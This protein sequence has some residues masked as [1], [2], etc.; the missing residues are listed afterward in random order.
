MPVQLTQTLRLKLDYSSSNG[1][2]DR[3]VG[4]IDLSERSSVAGNRLGL[5]LVG[6]IDV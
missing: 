1:L 6:M 5:V 3:E 4:G 2:G